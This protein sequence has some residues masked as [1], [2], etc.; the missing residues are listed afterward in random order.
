MELKHLLTIFLLYSLLRKEKKN[1]NE[2]PSFKTIM[3]SL[4]NLELYEAYCHI[5]AT[6]PSRVETIL[7][8]VKIMLTLSASTAQCERV[9]SQMKILKGRL[10]CKLTQAN[11]QAQLFN[12]IEGPNLK[13][14][15]PDK[16]IAFWLDGHKRHV[17][18]H[19]MI[20]SETCPTET[21]EKQID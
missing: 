8:L 9:F 13:S 3:N 6:C 20:M 18:G 1:L 5:V 15:S 14:F 12:M 7:K 19:K 4:N 10:R 2:F 16:C 11:L 17:G 21:T